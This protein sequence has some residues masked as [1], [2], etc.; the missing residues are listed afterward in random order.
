MHVVQALVSLGVGG[1]EMVAVETTEYLRA[2]GHKV[3]VVAAG[4][5]LVDRVS[6]AGAD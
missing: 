5:P 1:S 4:G 3:T 6:A 2:A